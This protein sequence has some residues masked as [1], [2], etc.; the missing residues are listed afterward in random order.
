MNT[1]YRIGRGIKAGRA[2]VNC[3]HMY[4]AHAAFGGYK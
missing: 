1:A 4:P 2:W 3:Y